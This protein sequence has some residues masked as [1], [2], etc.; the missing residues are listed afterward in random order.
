MSHLGSAPSGTLAET[1]SVITPQASRLC[2]ASMF[3]STQVEVGEKW[4]SCLVDKE[5]EVE[6]L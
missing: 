1:F 3:P 5:K 4:D 2:Q 6:T